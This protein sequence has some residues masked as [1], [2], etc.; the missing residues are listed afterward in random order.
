MFNHV[1]L[2][3]RLEYQQSS[4]QLNFFTFTQF[5]QPKLIINNRQIRN[6]EKIKFMMES[7]C[8]A[9][10]LILIKNCEKS[11]TKFFIPTRLFNS[12]QVR[13]DTHIDV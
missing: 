1:Q 9:K 6:K 4:L 10:Q 11:E 7:S 2:V 13:I 12:Y 8:T 3:Q 5:K